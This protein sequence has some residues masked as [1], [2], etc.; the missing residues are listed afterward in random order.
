[1]KAWGRVVD[2]V[3]E[4]R[5]GEKHHLN[6]SLR[7]N[8]SLEGNVMST[9]LIGIELVSSP[10]SVW[11][12]SLTELELFSLVNHIRNTVEKSKKYGFENMWILPY[13]KGEYLNARWYLVTCRPKKWNWA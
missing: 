2:W 12:I 3:V 11:F 10:K 13:E 9:L 7:N 6:I 4:F 5:S 1:M 8:G